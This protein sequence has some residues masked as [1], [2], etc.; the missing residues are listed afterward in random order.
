MLLGD[1]APPM[2]SASDD[3]DI[4]TGAVAA[5]IKNVLHLQLRLVERQEAHSAEKLKLADRIRQLER[6]AA[7][8]G[9]SAGGATAAP[10]EA[11]S[12]SLHDL[13]GSRPAPEPQG[14]MASASSALKGGLGKL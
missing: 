14:A 3:D 9:G 5:A 13:R 8:G 10:P 2:P 1:D 4:D 6:E 12:L 7:Q 11:K